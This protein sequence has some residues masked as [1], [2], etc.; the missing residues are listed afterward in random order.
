MP[1]AA[2][3]D[4]IERLS[5]VVPDFP[6]PGI[7]FRDL[8]PVF[9]DGP[10]LRAVTDALVE[11]FTGEF[12]VIA[13]VEARGFV[14][15]ASAAYATG[16]GVV[17]IRKPGKLPRAVLSQ[18]YDLEYGSTTLEVH[19]DELKRGSRVLLVDDVFATG[20]TLA[21]SCSLIERSGWLVAGISV[22]LELSALAGQAKLPGRAVHSLVTL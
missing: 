7:T 17:M 8:T 3:Q 9:A 5:R 15:A 10:A 4:A 14:L 11:P 16:L 21:A 2:A 20:G 1:S 12:D 19:P 22:V 13:G 6:S 18:D